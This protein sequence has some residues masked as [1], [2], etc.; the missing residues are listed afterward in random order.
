MFL[1]VLHHL[2]MQKISLLHLQELEMQDLQVLKEFRVLLGHRVLKEF[3]GLKEF[4][5]Q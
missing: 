4:K 3:R 2:L 1:E 5:V